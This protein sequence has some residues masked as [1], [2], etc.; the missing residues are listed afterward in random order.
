VKS[1]TGELSKPAFIDTGIAVDL[2]DRTEFLA[3]RLSVLVFL[4][5]NGAEGIALGLAAW[6][7]GSVALRAQTADNIAEFAVDVF[8]FIGVFRSVR[9]YDDAHPLGYGRERFFWSLFAALGIFVGG[10]GLSIEEAVRSA[11]HPSGVVS[12]PI[13][14]AVL[15]ITAALDAFALLVSLRPARKLAAERKI[16][17]HALL[18]TNSDPVL[19]TVVLSGGCAVVG[20]MLAAVGI[21]ASQIAGSNMPDTL[22]SALIG[23]LLIA[24]SVFLLHTNRELLTGR[25]VPSAMLIEMRRI[26]AAQSGVVAIQ[27]LFAVVV[28]PSSLVVNGDVTFS[29]DMTV[30]AVE[31]S[32]LDS[33]AALRQRWPSIEFVYLTPVSLPR[34]RRVRRRKSIPPKNNPRVKGQ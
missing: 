5:V 23:L 10:G 28:G 12:F 1:R 6:L 13:A 25:G 26:I 15:A 3:T 7:T 16:S 19:T 31:R 14:Y 29:D 4:A 33:A 17:L 32:I 24:T 18:L 20:A 8:L 9:A 21:G 2:V 22:A 27:D 34:A 11:L 30:S